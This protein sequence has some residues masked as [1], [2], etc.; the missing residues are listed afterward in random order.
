MLW[1]RHDVRELG[2]RSS[3]SGYILNSISYSGSRLLN[4][5]FYNVERL[6]HDH[7]NSCFLAIT[8]SIYIAWPTKLFEIIKN[9]LEKIV[10]EEAAAFNP[11]RASK[12]AREQSDKI[13]STKFS[14]LF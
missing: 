9:Y 1:L 14:K 4:M 7:Q 8:D 3:D 13:G 2:T 11:K 6:S 5:H 10:F 12:G